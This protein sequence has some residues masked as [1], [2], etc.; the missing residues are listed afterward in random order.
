MLGDLCV[1]MFVHACKCEKE[2]MK[3]KEGMCGERERERI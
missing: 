3:Y 2:S 1:C